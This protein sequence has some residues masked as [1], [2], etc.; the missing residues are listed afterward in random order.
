MS[1]LPIELDVG[2]RKVD[3]NYLKLPLTGLHFYPSNPR[4]SSIVSN[5][6]GKLTDERIHELMKDKQSEQTSS[7]FQQIKKDGVINEPL[8]VYNRQVLEGNTRLWAARELFERADTPEEKRKWSNLPCRDIKAKLTNEE[9]NHILCNVHIK[10]KRDWSPFEQACYMKTMKEDE[11]MSNEKI[12]EITAFHLPKIA[13]YIDVY[14][15]MVKHDVDSRDWN[16]YY[17]AYKDPQVKKVHVAGKIDIFEVIK[18]KTKQGKMGTAA[19]S[20]K[21]V[22]I[23]KSPRATKMF[24]K[25]DA[26]IYR[27][28]EAALIENPEEGDPLLK[29]MTALEEDLSHVE[30][31]K[32][33][34]YKKN[35]TKR[36]IIRKLTKTLIWVSKQLKLKV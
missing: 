23:L 1:E 16:R 8:V 19:D 24:V 12:R 35:K 25:D 20:R 29:R 33:N 14:D 6:K 3:T 9:I 31:E 4:I 11:K 28:Y 21:I 30:G 26:D 5:Y 13:N 7:L 2:K 27:A 32:I 17:E 34:E 22:K 36:E 15:E 10:K 18:K